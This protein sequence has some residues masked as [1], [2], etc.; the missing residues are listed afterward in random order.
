MAKLLDFMVRCNNATSDDIAEDLVR[1]ADPNSFDSRDEME[2]HFEECLGYNPMEYFDRKSIDEQ[3]DDLLKDAPY[4]VQ[5]QLRDKRDEIIERTLE[6][7]ED[8]GDTV[9]RKVF[10]SVIKDT[11]GWQPAEDSE[12]SLDECISM[13]IFGED[14]DDDN[15]DYDSAGD[16]EDDDEDDIMFDDD[17]ES[18]DYDD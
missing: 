14:I 8:V 13:A 17:D 4:S 11:I 3:F 10:V 5:D 16:D 15:S 9:L 12:V 6:C 7:S 2:M 1:M 18:S